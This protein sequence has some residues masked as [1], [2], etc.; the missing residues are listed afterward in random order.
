[1]L[2]T[3]NAGDKGRAFGR[4]TT[5]GAAAPLVWSLEEPFFGDVLN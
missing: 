1:M 2:A 4:I 3:D 5:V